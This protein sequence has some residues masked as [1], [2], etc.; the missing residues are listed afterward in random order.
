MAILSR[1]SEQLLKLERCQDRVAKLRRS[2][3]EA[4]EAEQAA[5]DAH[6]AALAMLQALPEQNTARI[7]G[8]LEILP[9]AP[10]KAEVEEAANMLA[11]R[12]ARRAHIESDLKEALRDAEAARVAECRERFRGALQG[13]APATRNLLSIINEIQAIGREAQ[14]PDL[15]LNYC[16]QT[17]ER[18]SENVKSYLAGPTKPTTPTNLVSVRFTRSFSEINSFEPNR[19]VGR[20]NAGEVAGF[21]REQADRLFDLGVAERFKPVQPEPQAA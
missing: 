19:I 20:F 11:A 2:L 6:T 1:K 3:N 12:S 8:G 10:I 4:K 17:I 16:R 7:A 5:S 9:V 15:D 18:V 13:L 21:T 14:L